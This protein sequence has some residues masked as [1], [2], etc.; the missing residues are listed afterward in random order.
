MAKNNVLKE[1]TTLQ[2]GKYVIQR[3]LGQGGFGITYEA[4][5]VK[6]KKRVAIK[7]S[8]LSGVCGR[9][10]DG[11][12]V[13]VPLDE[14]VSFFEKQ[15]ERFMDEA[16]RLAN[17]SNPHLVPVYDSFEENGTYYYVM[18]FIEG[19]SLNDKI[20]REKH[21]LD[22]DSV[23]SILDQLLDALDCIHS[24]D[25][26]LCHLDI[27]PANIMMNKK[28]KVV[29]VDF[30]ASKYASTAQASISSSSVVYTPGYAPF[31]QVYNDRKNMGPWTDFYATGA[32]LFRLLTGEKP[33]QLSD[34]FQDSSSDK[35]LS[36]PLPDHLSPMMRKLVLWMMAL[37]KGDRPQSVK[38]IR[39]FI[40]HYKEG[41]HEEKDDKN[42][43]KDDNE[44]FILSAKPGTSDHSDQTDLS[45]HSDQT[46]LSDHSGQTDLPDHSDQTDLSAP[47][48]SPAADRDNTILPDSGDNSPSDNSE[49]TIPSGES[50]VDGLAGFDNQKNPRDNVDTPEPKLNRR[51]L[52]AVGYGLVAGLVLFFLLSIMG[53]FSDS[54]T[55]QEENQGGQKGQV[56]EQGGQKEQPVVALNTEGEK[57][58]S[59]T[60]PSDQGLSDTNEQV[61][62]IAKQSDVEPKP[63][64]TPQKDEPKTTKEDPNEAKYKNY[65]SQ[66]RTAYNKGNYDGALASLNN[67]NALG[68]TY[69]SRS[70]VTKLRSQ[71]NT[72][73]AV[74]EKKLKE[75]QDKKKKEEQKQK[76]IEQKCR[77]LYN[78]ANAVV[79]TNP[80]AALNYIRQIENLSP[81]Y[82][83]RSDVQNLKTRAT[84]SKKNLDKWGL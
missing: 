64:D 7:E 56:T 4:T 43:G 63:E 70:D 38:E 81:S 11:K 74:K 71:I 42:N 23:M 57:E 8:F 5:L 73:K 26:P 29:L 66:A 79:K 17:L 83:K 75:E 37:K 34:I 61:K 60:S 13:V 10:K 35:H 18:D 48:N 80:D 41:C 68:K 6:L 49:A 25:P 24:E 16:L 3:K 27:K 32:T 22:E 52:K 45:D 40:N 20:K 82:A 54:N 59:T 30:G 69:S 65:L 76:E 31:E 78:S 44:V 9:G 62:D 1:G 12:T 51:W 58:D 15:R 14:N 28:G 72:A 33:S 46:D 84:Q 55:P 39:D 53:V 47:S 36:I 77:S 67:I 19:E 50:K 21:P 2:D